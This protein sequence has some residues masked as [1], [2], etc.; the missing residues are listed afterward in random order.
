MRRIFTGLWVFLT[1]LFT[2][3]G[4]LLLF[5]FVLPFDQDR[6]VI[7]R[8]AKDGS[9]ESFSAHFYQAARI[10]ALG[11][12][13]VCLALAALLVI[14]RP[15]ALGMLAAFMR[16]ISRLCSRLAGDMREML[17][18]LRAQAFRRWEIAALVGLLALA[19][20]ARAPFLMRPYYHDEAYTA[21]VFAISPV[22][23]FISDY[24][25]P[26]NHIF[27]TLLVH[28][29][30][31][32]WGLQP[33]AM[34]IPALLA[35]LFTIPAVYLLGRKLYNRW[36]ALA[37]GA[38][39]AALPALVDYSTAARG[40]TLVILFSLLGILLGLYVRGRPN[41]LAWAGLVLCSTLGFFTIPV[42]L[43]PFGA[44]L[45]WLFLCFLLADFGPR[46]TRR[47]FFTWLVGAGA[48]VA[49]LTLLL[50]LPVILR[51]G[52]GILISRDITHPMSW[53]EFFINFR[54][55]VGDHFA[56]IGQELPPLTRWLVGIGAVLSLVFAN[57]T[58]A[59]R[60]HVLLLPAVLGWT[61]GLFILLRVLPQQRFIIF[62]IPLWLLWALAGWLGLA[63]RLAQRLAPQRAGGYG[64]MLASPMLAG[65][66]LL[67]AL[68]GTGL[69]LSVHPQ[70]RFSFKGNVEQAMVFLQPRLQDM[71]LV[72]VTTP[73]DAI[74]W[75]YARL[76]GVNMDHFKREL[77]FMRV[78]VLV[79]G[80]FQTLES[81]L[82]ERGPEAFFLDLSTAH[83]VY[84][85]GTL[86]V[87]EITPNIDLVRKEYHLP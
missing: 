50:Y 51:M 9:M 53:T 27:H 43:A 69:R 84:R 56:Q 86:S 35:G 5:V 10:P 58:G 20:L 26:N 73:D 62:L 61:F 30:Y 72:V 75:Y 52:P 70:A 83:E 71:N 39:A 14:Q 76:Y 23:E 49:I 46:Y 7:D 47:S 44:L 78:Y 85:S 82:A 1:G 66:V 67:G 29:A 25:L 48:A 18:V 32:L 65:L 12:G 60:R 17:M 3:A 15:R 57:R 31:R 22:R 36:V 42:Y 77:P 24:H 80:A 41:L 59:A 11:L 81:V 2:L 6:A 19:I 4:F 40:Y 37:A 63:Q 33:W 34:R 13:L 28:I 45:T 8:L 16:G 68:A 79:D 74:T 87:V 55:Q 21:A 38:A 54:E 64:P